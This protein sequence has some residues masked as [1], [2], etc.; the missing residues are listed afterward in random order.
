MLIPKSKETKSKKQKQPKTKSERNTGS[1][2]RSMG[3]SR[4]RSMGDSRTL[5]STSA[6]TNIQSKSTD[7][8]K[9]PI[10]SDTTDSVVE[11]VTDTDTGKTYTDKTYNPVKDGSVFDTEP[12]DVA[13]NLTESDYS[14]DSETQNRISEEVRKSENLEEKLKEESISHS[15]Q[16]TQLKKK[17]KELEDLQDEETETETKDEPCLKVRNNLRLR[18]NPPA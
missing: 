10:T 4:S 13:I 8:D 15:N 11:T 3:D 1:R 5:Q 6:S 7:G 18:D 9:P 2:S 17:L 14:P 12:S 16:L